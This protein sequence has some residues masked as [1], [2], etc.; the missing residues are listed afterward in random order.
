MHLKKPVSE[1]DPSSG[2]N[3]VPPPLCPSAQPEMNDSVVFGIVGGTVDQPRV[4]YLAEPQPV[5]PELLGLSAPVEP[6]E[7]FRFAAPCAEHACQHFDGSRCRLVQRIVGFVAPVSDGLPPCRIRPACRWWQEEGREA[8][9]RCPLVVTEDY[10][11]SVQLA[12]AAD[13]TTPD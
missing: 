8:C 7:V 2:S 5:S 11:P 3:V 13:P 10:Q 12:Q 9:M 4:A 6:T 1:L